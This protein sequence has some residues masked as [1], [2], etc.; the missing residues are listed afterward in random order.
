MTIRTT[1]LVLMALLT[2][3]VSACGVAPDADGVDISTQVSMPVSTLPVTEDSQR[4]NPPDPSTQSCHGECCNFLCGN[5][6]VYRNTGV[7]CGD[8]NPFAKGY[9]EPKR[10]LVDAWW[11]NCH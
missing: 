4:L 7:G 6:R 3:L 10:G 1:P 9:C 2:M 11:G 8:C 5:G